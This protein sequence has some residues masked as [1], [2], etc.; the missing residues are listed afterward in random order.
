MSALC[1][2]RTFKEFFS[3]Q[4]K[5]PGTLAST[6]KGIAGLCLTGDDNASEECEPCDAS[7]SI[8]GW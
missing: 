4:K 5:D 2:E 8:P 3:H 6:P 1:Q 7:G